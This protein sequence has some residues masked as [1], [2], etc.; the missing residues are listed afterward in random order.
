MHINRR[1]ECGLRELRDAIVHEQRLPTAT[2]RQ[3]R[4]DHGGLRR[5]F[6]H[7]VHGYRISARRPI[8][9]EKGPDGLRVPFM[10]Q[11]EERCVREE[12][13]W[14]KRK[15]RVGSLWR[16]QRQVEQ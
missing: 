15:Q 4:E 6:A 12:T 2:P 8:C 9:R 3:C 11:S 1:G 14:A 5:S 13:T 10:V 16:G 7:V